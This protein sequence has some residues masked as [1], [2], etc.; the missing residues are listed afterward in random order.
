MRLDDAIERWGLENRTKLDSIEAAMV[1]RIWAT[2]RI[3]E[4]GSVDIDEMTEDDSEAILALFE[5]SDRRK[6]SMAL[7]SV[8]AW[9]SS[10]SQ[11]SSEPAAGTESPAK[12]NKKKRAPKSK[13]DG[14]KPTSKS[15]SK[16]KKPAATAE[17]S[18]PSVDDSVVEDVDLVVDESDVEE[19]DRL[20]HDLDR[21][22][23]TDDESPGTLAT[24]AVQSKNIRVMAAALLAVIL[25]LLALYSVFLA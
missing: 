10:R 20:V 11:S 16:S 21:E 22:S 1:R 3:S 7:N 9:A 2:V 18:N 14:K 13:P 6:V 12:S 8:S 24:K 25:V 5:P 4:S 15:K 23:E 17:K 19:P